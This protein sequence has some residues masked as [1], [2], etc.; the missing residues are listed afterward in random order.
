MLNRMPNEQIQWLVSEIQS[1]Y[2]KERKEKISE[3]EA[4]RL[5]DFIKDTISPILYNA[6]LYDVFRIIENQ[7]DHL[8]KEILQL[9]QPSTLKKLK[10]N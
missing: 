2:L 1:F 5:L 3:I 7:C 4:Q 10:F 8:E 9:E 6:I